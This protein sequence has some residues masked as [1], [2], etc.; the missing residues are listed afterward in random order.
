M[1]QIPN[2]VTQTIPLA[3]HERQVAD[4][5]AENESL[6]KELATGGDSQSRLR[7]G[8]VVYRERE[9]MLSVLLRLEF[10]PDART[11]YLLDSLL[12]HLIDLRATCLDRRGSAVL[13]QRHHHALIWLLQHVAMK[14]LRAVGD[15]DGLPYLPA[16]A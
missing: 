14:G 6:R 3:E 15:D 10:R 9:K 1:N 13:V 7:L 11:V 5:I 2:P 12:Q 4:L 8:E 16:H